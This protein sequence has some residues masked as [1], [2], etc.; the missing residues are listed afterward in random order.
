MN[1]EV[2]P[3]I[4]NNILVYETKQLRT[5]WQEGLFVMEDFTLA[6]DIY[7]NGPIFFSV[8]SETNEDKFGHFTYYLPINDQVTLKDETHFQ[9]HE[10]F[11]V[12]EALAMRQADQEVDFHAAYQKIKNYAATED[13]PI[14]DTYFVVLLEVYGDIIIDLYVP[15]Q[16]RSEEK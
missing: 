9:F 12:E 13:I 8:T 6:E 16:D 14:E 4:F 11:I 1:I 10:S 3:L 7:K 15:I 2:R 5:D